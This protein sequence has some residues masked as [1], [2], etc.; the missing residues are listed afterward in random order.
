[1]WTFSSFAE[2]SVMNEFGSYPLASQAPAQ[3]FVAVFWKGCS[4][5]A[6]WESKQEFYPSSS[7]VLGHSSGWG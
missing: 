1:M 7:A 6:L 2:K 3:L 5:R 4:A